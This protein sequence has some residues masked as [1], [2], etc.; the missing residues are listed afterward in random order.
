MSSEIDE[1]LDDP[2]DWDFFGFD[3]DFTGTFP[4]L[5]SVYTP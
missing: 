1:N 3:F 4:L 2:I 5:L